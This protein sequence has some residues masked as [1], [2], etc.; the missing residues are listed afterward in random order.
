MWA[1]VAC[2]DVQL[3]TL[4]LS[5]TKVNK[6]FPACGFETVDQIMYLGIYLQATLSGSWCLAKHMRVRHA[7]AFTLCMLH[8]MTHGRAI[9]TGPK[10]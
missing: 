4:G 2:V 9:Q 6:M 8:C 5:A 7:A 1:Q 10:P 3:L